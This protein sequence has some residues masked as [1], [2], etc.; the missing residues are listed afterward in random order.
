MV[1]ENLEIHVSGSDKMKKAKIVG[2]KAMSLRADPSD[3]ELSDVTCGEIKM[4]ETVE[5]NTDDEAWSWD[6]KHFFKVVSEH[7]LKGY[8][9]SDCLQFNGGNS[10]GQHIK[11]N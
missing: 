4:N 11:N 3:T 10:R 6:D 9:N 8:A 7:G 2:C 1:K 5:V